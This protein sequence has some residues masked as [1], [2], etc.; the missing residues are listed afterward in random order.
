MLSF[1]LSSEQLVLN[2]RTE[3]NSQK[4]S[5]ELARVAW[6]PVL[7]EPPERGLPWPDP[8][9]AG[10]AAPKDVRQRQDAWLVSASL[11]LLEGECRSSALAEAF[12]WSA[13]PSALALAAQ[14]AALARAHRE[15][16]SG[17][18][19]LK[20]ALTA[21]LP[22]IYT[23]L[24]AAVSSEATTT[25]NPAA[26]AAATRQWEEVRTVLRGEPCV[27]VGEGFAPPA[28][29]AFEG[30]LVLA[31]YLHVL[32]ADLHCF[33]GLLGRLGVRQAFE[34][35]D[36]VQARTLGGREIPHL[37]FC[38]LRCC[39]FVWCRRDKPRSI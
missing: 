34:P 30:P 33:R 37:M 2:S 8:P 21:A 35:E 14:L 29:V 28:K 38:I 26:A 24:D 5:Q 4:P 7:T 27:W 9:Q 10:L 13:S 39:V 16:A 32:P 22:R 12:G 19:A 3:T 1:L 6:C 17:D 31:P 23:L 18:T 11:R 36:F 20:Q 25:T 15:V